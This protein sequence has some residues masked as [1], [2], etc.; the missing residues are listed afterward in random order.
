MLALADLTAGLLASFALTIVGNGQPGQFAWALLWVPAWVV[1]A[2]LLGLYDRDERSLRHLTVNEVPLLVLWALVGTTLLALFLEITPAGRPQ[3]S[4][5]VL[6][7]AVATVA[8][9]VLRGLM[10]LVW[11]RVTPPEPIAVIGPAVNADAVRRKL[12]LFPGPA[13]ADR[14]DT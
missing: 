9:L 5:A 1:S 8:A 2:K 13:H 7:G 10:R 11:R 12:E 6:A 4:S 3:A 14:R